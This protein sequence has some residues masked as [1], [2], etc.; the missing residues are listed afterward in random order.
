MSYYLRII[1]I[2]RVEEASGLADWHYFSLR[3]LP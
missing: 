1:D 2:D 3:I